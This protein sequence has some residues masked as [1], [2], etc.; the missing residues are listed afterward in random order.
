MSTNK[1]IQ[2]NGGMDK[3]EIERTCAYQRGRDHPWPAGRGS[4]GAD[5]RG[6]VCA[7]S[8]ATGLPCRAL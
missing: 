7:Y 8:G 5:Q 2:R 3:A 4:K 6:A 1:I